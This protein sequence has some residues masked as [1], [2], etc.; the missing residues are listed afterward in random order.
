[1]PADPTRDLLSALKLEPEARA[2]RRRRWPWL[3]L[4]AALVVGVATWWFLTHQ[5]V[6]VKTALVTAPVRNTGGQKAVLEASGYVTARRQATVA[7]KVTGRVQELL[8]EEGDAVKAGQVLARLDVT[9]ANAALALAKAQ[10]EAAVSQLRDLALQSAQAGRDLKRQ[11]EL[12]ARKLTSPQS[13][14]DARLKLDSLEARE[15]VQRRQV[16]V[17]ERSV[18]LAEVGVENTIIRAPFDGVVTVKAAQPGEIVSPI[19][20]G[21][22]FTRTGI[23][24]LV[25]MSS[26]EIEVDVNEAYVSRVQ[27]G[28]QVTAVLN[29][30]PDWQ[31]P[32]RV[33]TLI[34]TADRAKATVKAR[35]AIAVQDPRIVP[36]MGVRVSFL[37]SAAQ[38]ADA[39]P[40]N[41]QIPV[42]A[43]R[44]AGD[45][46]VVF[47]VANDTAR[48]REVSAGQRTGE[49]REITRGLSVGERVVLSPPPTLQDGQRVREA[50]R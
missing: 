17:A 38:T 26:L 48:R 43:L 40:A 42:A 32:A 29:A 41:P 22:G 18:A 6:L 19:S 46:Q 50:E 36:D 28:Q 33:I 14:E 8:L 21:G 2:P 45:R 13:V 4:A 27:P 16:A 44:E 31:L 37:E 24:T 47:V 39:P 35:I 10:H 11:Q 25:D 7:S 15:T 34:P 12:A 5:A 3:L 20:A 49:T 1:M 23:G 30:Y 9:D